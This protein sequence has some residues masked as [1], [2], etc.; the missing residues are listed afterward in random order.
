MRVSQSSGA[1]GSLM[2]QLRAPSLPGRLVPSQSLGDLSVCL[3]AR[4][5]V[6]PGDPRCS[7]VCLPHPRSLPRW[8]SRS[9]LARSV[10]TLGLCRRGRGGGAR[11]GGRGGSCILAVGE[12]SEPALLVSR[13]AQLQPGGP[14]RPLAARP[15]LPGWA[16]ARPGAGG[17]AG[18]CPH[19]GPWKAAAP[20]D[21]AQCWG[22]AGGIP[23]S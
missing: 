17:G 10:S 18:Q 4:P 21:R 11:E 7:P 15:G 23:E 2:P 3:S 5:P 16:R 12:E 22:G 8:L 9:L 19:P 14:A 20:G 13:R 6:G 1:C